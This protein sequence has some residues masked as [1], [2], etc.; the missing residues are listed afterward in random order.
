MYWVATYQAA[1]L[2][3]KRRRCCGGRT[4]GALDDRQAHAGDVLGRRAVVARAHV[5]FERRLRADLGVLGFRLF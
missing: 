3:Y 4:N 1:C 2:L 5:A